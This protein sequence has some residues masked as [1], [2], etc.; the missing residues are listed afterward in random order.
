MR[1][2]SRLLVALI[3]LAGVAGVASPASAMRDPGPIIVCV[4]EP[5]PGIP[6]LPRLPP[7]PL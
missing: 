4:T 1:A 6:G 5:C 7:L 3:A 2:R